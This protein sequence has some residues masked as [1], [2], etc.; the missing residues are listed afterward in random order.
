MLEG[1]AQ[2][3]LERLAFALS[4]SSSPGSSCYHVLE[5]ADR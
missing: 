1:Q 3:L 5:L 4:F 2:Y